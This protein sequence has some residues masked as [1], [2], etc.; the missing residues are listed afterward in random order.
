MKLKELTRGVVGNPEVSI[1]LDPDS[2]RVVMFGW[3]V[4][5]RQRWAWRQERSVKKS[6]A[7]RW[8]LTGGSV[9]RR[10][11][12]VRWMRRVPGGGSGSELGGAG[13]GWAMGLPVPDHQV[14]DLH[15]G[16]EGTWMLF[17]WVLRAKPQGFLLSGLTTGT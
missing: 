6:C 10:V 14:R 5:S 1:L 15:G 17:L 7:G 8:C 4:G 2:S 11:G 3:R 13:A 9:L 16:W 12:C